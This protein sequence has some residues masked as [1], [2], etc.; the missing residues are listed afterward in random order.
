MGTYCIVGWTV[1]LPDPAH[2][3]WIKIR[4]LAAEFHIKVSPQQRYSLKWNHSVWSHSKL[5]FPWCPAWQEALSGDWRSQAFGKQFTFRTLK[6]ELYRGLCIYCVQRCI[7]LSEHGLLRKPLP[8]LECYRPSLEVWFWRVKERSYHRIVKSNFISKLHPKAASDGN[9]WVEHTHFEM[10]SR[11][12]SGSASF[13]W[14][15]SLNTRTTVAYSLI[16][17]KTPS[18]CVSL[19]LCKVDTQSAP[20]T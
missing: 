8:R 13:R 11:R 3:R 7:F 16:Y 1:L 4:V 19:N 5:N 15:G 12:S 10:M 18:D 9:Q 2:A 17:I 14:S 6:Q 20:Q